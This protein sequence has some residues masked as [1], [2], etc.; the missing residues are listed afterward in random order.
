MSLS[1]TP[2]GDPEGTEFSYSRLNHDN[3]E[4]P[5]LVSKIEA[6][7]TKPEDSKGADARIVGLRITYHGGSRSG[8][9]G[10]SD[11][12]KH[13]IELEKG[14]RITNLKVYGFLISY[15]IFGFCFSTDRGRVLSVPEKGP[16]FVM[17]LDV[18]VASGLLVGVGGYLDDWS[19]DWDV[20]IGF[21]FYFL[22]SPAFLH[23]DFEYLSEPDPNAIQA[24]VLESI[25]KDNTHG[26]ESQNVSIDRTEKL[27]N[28]AETDESWADGFGV[29]V[30]VSMTIFNVVGEDD[31]TS[32]KTS[33]QTLQSTSYKEAHD[34][35][36]SGQVTVPPHKHYVIDL[37][38]Y[39]GTVNVD[40]KAK[41]KYVTPIGEEV[42]WIETG[43]M[44]GVSRGAAVVSTKDVTSQDKVKKM[45]GDIERQLTLRQVSPNTRPKKGGSKKKNGEKQ[46]KQEG[47]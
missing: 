11:G 25:E 23:V 29:N 47:D 17:A 2:V 12:P 14:E 7:A 5:Q 43:T 46:E 41:I 19:H 39:E 21:G 15:A 44:R 31:T 32:C 26:E 27:E 40:Y 4:H 3:D 33:T 35:S 37:V 28:T 16:S 38:Y 22:N 8:I 1:Y 20:V 10:E 13:T 18:P 36:W 45:I 6:W 34:V 30:T 24:R 9:F 42:K